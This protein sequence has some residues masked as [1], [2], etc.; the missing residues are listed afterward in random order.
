[1]KASLKNE[2]KK[3]DLKMS[4]YK[5]I[6]LDNSINLLAEPQYE[7]FFNNG[8]NERKE[9]GT[10]RVL[11]LFS[12]CGGMDIGLEGGFICH[13]RSV[14]NNEWI[15]HSISKDWVQLNRNLFRTVFACDILNEARLTWLRYMSRYNIN[16]DIYHLTSIV[17][18]V[19]LHKENGTPSKL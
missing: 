10:L 8:E 4:R 15:H 11:S 19:K 5:D 9:E 3:I 6:E 16:P 2:E 14:T 17:D 12:G 13:K 1:M 7:L 18:L